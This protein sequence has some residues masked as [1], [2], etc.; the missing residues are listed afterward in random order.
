MIAFAMPTYD[1]LW[2]VYDSDRSNVEVRNALVGKHLA[3][4]ESLHAHLCVGHS[5]DRDSVLE[6]GWFALIRAVEKFTLGRVQF[7]SYAKVCCCRAMKRAI[8]RQEPY[9]TLQDDVCEAEGPAN[10]PEAFAKRIAS[11]SLQERFVVTLRYWLDMPFSQIGL[12]AKCSEVAARN[13]WQRAK[14]TLRCHADAE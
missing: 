1:P 10:D 13:S 5:I 9:C 7:Y 3:W 14:T 8:L 11:L 2:H 4:L 6:A 12:L